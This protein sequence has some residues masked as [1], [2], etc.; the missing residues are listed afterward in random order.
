MVAE[1][2]VE[3][4]QQKVLVVP[5]VVLAVDTV[6][7]TLLELERLVLKILVVEEAVVHGLV[8]YG[9]VVLVVLVW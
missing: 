3:Q 7:L 6:V 8:K 5:A 1:V 4:K 9:K 2:V